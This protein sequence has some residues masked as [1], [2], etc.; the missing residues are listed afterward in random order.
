MHAAR[1][2]VLA[3]RLLFFSS[4]VT[5]RPRDVCLTNA[6]ILANTQPTWASHRKPPPSLWPGHRTARP[7]RS[8]RLAARTQRTLGAHTAFTLKPTLPFSM[9][10]DL[11]SSLQAQA[12]GRPSQ[13]S[14][15]FRHLHLQC[16]P[17]RPSASRS[18]CGKRNRCTG[19]QNKPFPFS[20]H[21]RRSFRRCGLHR[22]PRVHR[23]AQLR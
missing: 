3:L 10:R 16:V 12:S 18:S 6:F 14:A 13:L 1:L 20:E 2:A 15:F 8:P 5:M 9:G 19:V 22:P 4:I 11:C 7:I 17:P 23:L 21:V